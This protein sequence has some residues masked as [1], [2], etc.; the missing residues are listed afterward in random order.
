MQCMRA[1]R[2]K[3]WMVGIPIGLALLTASA[4]AQSSSGQ[5]TPS[6]PPQL[7][8]HQNPSGS[9]SSPA[10]I[11][12]EENVTS[13]AASAATQKAPA[14]VDPTGPATSI[15]T[16]ESMFDVMAA[17]NTCG[18]NE[19]V[20]ISDPVRQAVRDNINQALMKSAAARDSRD[21]LCAYIQP[22]TMNSAKLSLAAY[23]SLALYLN[24]PPALTPNVATSDL[25][26][27]AGPL[28]DFLPHLRDFAQA[29]NLHLVWVLNRPAYEAE[30]VKAHVAVSQMLVQMDLYLRQPPATYG[31]RRFLVIL[32]PLIAPG[33]VNARVY[34]GDYIV[35]ESPVNGEIDLKPVK[36]TYLRFVLEPLIYARSTA[37]DRLTPILELVQPSPLPYI[38][39]SDVLTL[40]TECM[41][42]AIEAHTMDTG[43][44]VY[45]VP[46]HIDRNQ[47]VAV[48]NAENAYE[49]KVSAVRRQTVQSDMVQGF[50]LTKYFYDQF[51]IFQQNSSTLQEAVGEM[52]YGMNVDIEKRRVQD[53][54]FASHTD[55][56]VVEPVPPQSAALDEGERKLIAGDTAG[57][58]QLA[59]RALAEHTHNAG[60]AEFILAR[61]DIMSGNMDGAVQAFRQAIQVSHNLRTVAWSH[62]YLGRLDDLEGNRTAAIAEYQAAMQSRDGKADTKNAAEVGLKAPF[63]PPQAAQDAPQPAPHSNPP[64]P[65]PR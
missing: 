29:V 11:P 20:S 59:Q 24:P 19:G 32:E 37:I 41:I 6:G 35:V 60:R 16:S 12:N 7:P 9:T 65:Q 51:T 61:A 36:H 39:K 34:G 44:P 42:R 28:V 52:V 26:P 18:Y 53:I 22:H 45:K 10:S 17:L 14:A 38:Y 54:V 3:F 49:R 47:L 5:A 64:T 21:R 55:E 50:I 31:T 13:Q 40:V 30:V 2:F 23:I 48:N 8:T 1:A 62:I 25:P 27:D 15:E 46:A 33:E 57:A 4:V 43:V 63:A 56:D 58:A